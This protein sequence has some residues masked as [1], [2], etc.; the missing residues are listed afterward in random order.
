MPSFP[1]SSVVAK[2]IGLALFGWVT[3]SNEQ[4]PAFQDPAVAPAAVSYQKEIRPIL[5]SRC[6]GCHQP[7]D[8]RGDYIMTRFDDLLT[9]GASDQAAITPGEPAKS[10]ILELVSPNA[11]GKVEMPK[12]G[13]PLSTAQIDLITRWIAE[14]ANDDS[15]AETQPFDADHPPTYSTPPVITAIDFSPDGSLM[16]VNG[17]HEVLLLST[18]DWTVSGRLIGLSQRIE[19]VQFSPD[20]TK[21][22][23]TGGLPGQFGEVQIWNVAERK[24]IASQP[25]THDSIYGG[26]W[27]GDAKFVAFGCADN[28]VRVLDASSLQQI[29]FQGAHSDWVLDVAF[30]TDASHII[31]VGRD[32]TCKLTEVATN[33]FIDN[34]TSITP[35][36]LKGGLAAIARHPQRDEIVVGGSDGVPRVYRIHRL[37]KRVIGDDANMIR[38]LPELVGRIHAV[39]VSKDGRRILA[40]S[41]LDRQGQLRIYSYDFDTSLP[42]NIKAINEKVVTSRTPE[43]NAALDAYRVSGIQAIGTFDAGQ[44]GLYAAVFHPSGQ[45]IAAGGDN[46]EI[47]LIDTESGQPKHRFIAAPIQATPVPTPVVAATIPA[48]NE[49]ATSENAV[50]TSE[51]VAELSV[52]PFAIDLNHPFA[53]CQL[54]VTA[55]DPNGIEFD[56]TRAASYTAS[57]QHVAISARGR[58]TPISDGTD[59]LTISLAGKSL[60]V[61]VTVA[62]VAESFDANFIRDINPVLCRLGCNAGTCHGSQQGKN[63]F[64]LS[65]RGYDPIADVRSF[66]DDLRCRRINKASPENSLMLAKSS[67]AVPHGGGVVMGR[68]SASFQLLQNWIASGAKLDLATPRV[69]G[70]QVTP[71]HRILQNIGDRQQV[72]VVATYADG[73]QRDVTSLAF[74]ESGNTEVLEIDRACIATAKRRGDAPLLVRF[75]GNYDTAMLTV[76]G[77]RTGFAWSDV[78]VNNRID[79]LVA[80]KWKEL[81]IQ[82]SPL[83]SD[84]DFLRRVYLDLTGLPP[85]IEEIRAF[86]ADTRPTEQK[87]AECIDRLIGCPQYVD[88]WTNKW[89]DLL[90]VNRKYLG[91]ESAAKFREWI[92]AQVAINKPYD[93]FVRDVIGASGSNAENPAVD[94]YKIHRTPSQLM[95][96][97]THLFLGIRF[98]CN[99]CHDHPFERWTQDQYYQ[100][101]AYF[102]HVSLKEDAAASKGQ[103]IGGTDVEPA[104]PLFEILSD[105]PGG[106]VR[107]DRTGKVTDPQFPYTVDVSLPADAPRRQQIAAWISSPNNPYFARSYAN[108]IWSYLLG[109]GLIEPVDDIRAGNPASNPEL[110]DYL[111]Q[112]FVNSGF[113]TRHL[114]KTICNSRTYQLAIETNAFNADDTRHYSHAQARRLPAEVLYDA[115]H[116]VLGVKPQIPGVAEGVR[117]VQLPDSGVTVPNGF[118]TAL[119]RPARESV[120]ECE[121][122]S[123][124][125]LGP[126]M[127]LATG[128]V[129]ATALI[130]ESNQ[131]RQLVTNQAD[132]AQLVDELFLRIVNRSPTPAETGEILG[133]WQGVDADHQQLVA[134]LQQAQAEFDGARPQLENERLERIRQLEMSLAESDAKLRPDNE[135]RAAERLANIASLEGQVKMASDGLHKKIVDWESS[136]PPPTTAWSLLEPITL[137]SKAAARL[138]TTGDRRILV[139]ETKGPDTYEIA[140]R[141]AVKRVTS[142]RLETLTDPS[143][144]NLGPGF[145]GNGNFVV[146]EFELYY[147]ADGSVAEWQK[148]PLRSAVGD[149]SQEQFDVAE[150]IDG[151]ISENENGWAVSPRGRAVHWAVF[152]LQTPIEMTTSGQLRAVIVNQYPNEHQLACFRLSATSD[153]GDVGLGLP[154]EFSALLRTPLEHRSDALRKPLREYFLAEDNQLRMLEIQLANARQPLPPNPELVRLQ[155]LLEQA[156]Q[157]LAE[158]AAL[159]RL[160]RDVDFS[161]RQLQNKRLT[162]AEDLAW[163]LI[164]SPSFLFNR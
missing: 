9:G 17:F 138:T 37:T 133:V 151:I 24:L 126:V 107:H 20:G 27:S 112:E 23:V 50:F 58:V 57:Q 93:Q 96:S 41:S 148:V 43:E 114:V 30:S 68:D 44:S 104:R 72:R 26:C 42:D 14:G 67:G 135:R 111:T 81:K 5:Q 116:S 102:A 6:W 86:L 88:Y 160:K 18:A 141:P 48:N 64:K 74:I 73:T 140:L 15:V 121:R 115:I 143:L 39:D 113:N 109:T 63:G 149:F 124:L 10:H 34:V 82:P 131:L 13:D 47:V 90:Q 16:A 129:V 132:D 36:V 85:T 31:S 130:N 134:Q 164:N 7:A 84:T 98:N 29:L 11:E 61:P 91:P 150:M 158:P 162:N 156:R 147:K 69:T 54:V 155:T 70:I 154:E 21:L 76:M 123:D 46:G 119:G 49:S 117:A 118:L 94:Y 22:L 99:K 4:A 136:T 120:C 87:R 95:E 59:Q 52:E 101:A 92:H 62:H 40:A 35:G 79:E 1:R 77:D 8:D 56:V 103:Q 53:E 146:N 106:Q 80:A 139:S 3:F 45:F 108:R 12:S 19:S 75:E 97:T 161:N 2:L 159:T 153:D 28:T 83:C 105:D 51:Q 142:I 122:R 33:R 55:R 163:A 32:M 66:T 145:P 152:Q 38:Q 78:P 110:L 144:P 25:I 89:S 137:S 127:A 65:L 157:P 100:T 125:P 60:T 71:H 128:P